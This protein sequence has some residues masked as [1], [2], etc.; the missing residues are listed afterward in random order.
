MKK[1]NYKIYKDLEQQSPEWFKLRA[2]VISWTSLNKVIREFYKTWEKKVTQKSLWK[3]NN[4]IYELLGWE[5]SFDENAPNTTTYLLNAWNEFE[6]LAKIK[7][8]NITWKKVD[9]VWFIK[10]NDWHW[11]SPDWII[12]NKWII[13]KAIEIKSPLWNNS[14][15]FYKYMFENKIPDEYLWQIVNY[16]LVIDTLDELDFVVFNP[17]F[18]K[19][20]KQ[21]WIKTIKREDLKEEIERAEKD[22]KE[23][24]KL[25]LEKI[26]ILLKK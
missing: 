20:E 16:F 24:R 6:E 21:L 3:I 9:E 14:L 10:R 7:Y 2:W 25:W 26:Q 17:N 19:T 22:L 8:E 5:F 13:T 11:L 4:F 15:N 12:F 23:F 18:V 1:L